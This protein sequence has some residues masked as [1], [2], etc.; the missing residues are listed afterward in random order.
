[1]PFF[2]GLTKKEN[3]TD[4]HYVYLGI[5]ESVNRVSAENRFEQM[6]K[7]RMEKEIEHWTYDSVIDTMELPSDYFDEK[8]GKEKVWK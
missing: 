7:E 3:T 4:S 1:M 8:P 5:I 2:R 6:V